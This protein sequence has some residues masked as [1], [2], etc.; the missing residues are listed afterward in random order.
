VPGGLDAEVAVIGVG[1][2]GSMLMWQLARSGVPAL[3]FERHAPG[4]DR[5]AVGGETRLF[6]MA[7]AEGAQYGELL[8][9]APRYWRE[10]EVESETALLV[11][12][13]G[14]AI[15]ELSGGYIDLPATS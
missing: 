3:G 15:G 11:Q 10:L 5:G 13:G 8:R 2:V 7:Y 1:T 6:R 4:H 14:L 9:Q 12:C